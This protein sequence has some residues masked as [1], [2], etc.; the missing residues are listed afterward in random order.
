MSAP[1][2]IA[3][4]SY[5]TRALLERCL[6]SLQPE[7][8]A[9][10]ASVW[11]VDNASSDGSAQM[12]AERFGWAR[13]VASTE[14]LG[15]GRAVNA[16]AERTA[17]E[18]LVAANA[19]VELT[20]GAL[21]A[22]LECGARHPEAGAV[23]PRLVLPDGRTQHSVYAFPTLRF[24]ALFNLGVPRLSARLA[25]RLCLE[26]RWDADRPREVDWA[27]GAFL[28][29]RRSAFDQAGG[30]DPRQWLWAEDLEL[31]WRLAQKGWKTRYEPLAVVR[32][33]DSAATVAAFG[34]GVESAEWAA[35]YAALARRFGPWRARTTAAL[36]TG[37]AA[38][39][40][41]AFRLLARANPARW[42]W[43]RDRAR[44]W[45]RVH[46]SGLTSALPYAGEQVLEG[47]EAAKGRAAE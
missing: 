4:V 5:E 23:A 32:H 18:W 39:R 10:R 2:T 22:L 25:D 41:L 38:G 15:F 7:W 21:P 35:T 20:P 8:E 31:G 3:V 36:N 29:V 37:G 45:L 27:I 26:G 14:N 13:L 46:R 9:G 47:E 24:T 44:E 40:W 33:A 1:V 28:L 19:D 17:G 43:R 30:F 6:A 12:V 34:S 42:G 11:V 16:V